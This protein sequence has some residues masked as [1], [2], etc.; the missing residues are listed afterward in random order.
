MDYSVQV[1][2][3]QARLIDYRGE[4][5]NAVFIVPAISDETFEVEGM[6]QRLNDPE[7]RFL[8]CEIEDQ[9]ELVQVERIAYVEFHKRLP[10]LARLEEVGARKAQVS[11][12][13]ANDE[14]VSGTLYYEA[15]EIRQRVSDL[16]NSD[17]PRFLVLVSPGVVR[18]VNRSAI[19]RARV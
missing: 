7:G 5:V 18:L 16:L 15:P 10:S 4:T 14:S 2:R 9:V 12:R 19:Y 13:L 6:L 8:P 17:R 1:H 3:I 11:L